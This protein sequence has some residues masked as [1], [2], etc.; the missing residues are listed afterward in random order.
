VRSTRMRT[1]AMSNVRRRTGLGTRGGGG[2]LKNA[3][4]KRLAIE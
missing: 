2:I 3:A 4:E 1:I